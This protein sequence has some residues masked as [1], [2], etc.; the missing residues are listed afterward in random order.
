[1][2]LTI[3]GAANAPMY[4]FNGDVTSLEKFKADTGYIPFT[5]G[6]NNKTLLI[7]PGGGRDVLYV[8]RRRK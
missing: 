3:D 7:G 5:I 2:V 6:H 8:S 4:Q 1:M